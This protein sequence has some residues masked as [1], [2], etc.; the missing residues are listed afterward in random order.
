MIV[1]AQLLVAIPLTKRRPYGRPMTTIPKLWHHHGRG[2][3]LENRGGHIIAQFNN[4]NERQEY[5]TWVTET[6]KHS[7]ECIS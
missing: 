3:L 2:A 4:H 6:D 5:I 7:T 1:Y